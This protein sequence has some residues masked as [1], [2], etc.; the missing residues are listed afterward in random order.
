[1]TTLIPKFEQP[2]TNAVNR[3]TNLKLQETVSVMDFAAVGDGTTDD[4][5]AI[6]AAINALQASSVY[7]PGGVLYFPFGV[8]LVSTLSVTG[9]IQ[10]YGEGSGTTIT[11]N[12]GTNCLTINMAQDQHNDV[13][14]SNLTFLGTNTALSNMIYIEQCVNI[15]VEN[16]HFAGFSAAWC[17]N[18][19]YGYGL[20]VDKCVF[21]DLDSNG[22]LLQGVTGSTTAYSFVTR[23]RDCDFSRLQGN[24]I[25]TQIMQ[26]ILI[27]SCV[28]QGIVQNAIDFGTS[29]TTLAATLINCWFEGNTLANINV[30]TGTT[31]SM[32]LINPVFNAEASGGNPYINIGNATRLNIL[33][34]P[35]GGG[36]N[37]T[38]IYGS[39]G[40]VVNIFGNELWVQNGDF[41]WNGL[42][43]GLQLGQ[44]TY[45]NVFS[46][47]SSSGVTQLNGNNDTTFQITAPTGGVKKAGLSLVCTGTNSA[48]FVYQPTTNTLQ[49][50]N[51]TSG[52]GVSLA[53]GG[54]SWGSY[55]D[56]RLKENLTPISD[57]LSKVNTLRAVT[58]KYKTDEAGT[59]RSFLI[60]QDVQAVLPE[61]VDT[62]DKDALSLRYVDVIPLLVASI[63]E[64]KLEID[65][66]KAK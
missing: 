44:G 45:S 5:A 33:G 50:F 39:S 8:Y 21:N 60:A 17:I 43:P 34:I 15:T 26:D 16:C 4:T 36:S 24:A 38:T 2:L 23:I 18:H 30:G 58:G 35:G 53:A 65:T 42:G 51:Q 63:K 62:S 40:S 27:D 37:P 19:V 41:E 14:I 56:E 48:G 66:L 28:I 29:E 13:V 61:A 1:M 3:P 20:L 59:S 7:A 52:T 10:F 6:Q 55:S 46:T 12:S 11:T 31:C 47:N 22:I 57:A 32:T 49:V 25:A 64:L 9:N 54:T